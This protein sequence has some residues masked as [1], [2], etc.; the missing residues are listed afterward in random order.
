MRVELRQTVLLFMLST[1]LVVACGVPVAR[2]EGEL[3]FQSVTS[4]SDSKGNEYAEVALIGVLVVV[5]SLLVILGIRS[6]M[7]R[8]EV[9]SANQYARVDDEPT[10][11]LTPA[12]L[13]ARF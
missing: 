9:S 11:S 1:M 10:I 3:G 2:G 6:D 5:V 8:G 7:R 13:C 12:G 4:G